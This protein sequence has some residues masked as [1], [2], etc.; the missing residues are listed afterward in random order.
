MLRSCRCHWWGPPQSPSGGAQSWE[1][2]DNAPRAQLWSFCILVHRMCWTSMLSLG[3][4]PW[5]KPGSQS[6]PS[7]CQMHP[8]CRR[9]GCPMTAVQRRAAGALSAAQTATGIPPEQMEPWLR[10]RE[11]PCPDATTRGRDRGVT[12]PTQAVAACHG[13]LCAHRSVL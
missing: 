11:L 10:G 7:M 5:R 3:L 6:P 4:K 8:R 13:F 2:L 9:R 12:F 1:P